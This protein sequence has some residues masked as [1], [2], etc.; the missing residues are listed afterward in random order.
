MSEK[1]KIRPKFSICIIAKDEAGVLKN[2]AESLNFFMENGG[3]VILLDTGSS[4]ETLDLAAS[5]GFKTHSHVDS[6]QTTI[7]K[8]STK[9]CET[10]FW[11]RKD[12]IFPVKHGRKIFDFSKARNKC[13]SLASND[14]ILAMDCSDVVNVLD[15]GYINTFIENGYNSFYYNLEVRNQEQNTHTFAKANRLYDRR[16]EEFR[17]T[18]H[19]SLVVFENVDDYKSFM[20]PK[21]VF[22]VTHNRQKKA[23]SNY[24]PGLIISLNEKKED[25][26]FTYMLA[27]QFMTNGFNHSALKLFE[28]HC[29][30]QNGL[31]TQRAQSMIYSGMIYEN[32]A[33][34]EQIKMKE[35]QEEQSRAR[36][37]ISESEILAVTKRVMKNYNTAVDFYFKSIQ[38]NHGSRAPFIRMAEVYLN[39]REPLRSIT[40]AKAAKTVKNN[41]TES[42]DYANYTYKIDEILFRAYYILWKDAIDNKESDH[43]KSQWFSLGKKHWKLCK[44]VSGEIQTVK[45]F[46]RI[47]SIDNMFANGSNPAIFERK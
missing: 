12:G 11:D 46:S 28:R 5:L 19:E 33:K 22:N 2:L 13:A 47:F 8:Q 34:L 21:T 29:D 41:T 45:N 36:V 7:S 9:Y 35:K 15:F 1:L 38:I 37:P 3:E 30:M 17:G 26:R 32:F 39:T 44:N 25:A 24:I 10:K 43:K 42:E 27:V 4:D 14:M 40:W 18:C 20:L 16:I 6:F 31:Q 23:R